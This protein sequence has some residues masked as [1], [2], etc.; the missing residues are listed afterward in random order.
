MNQWG[1]GANTQ[2]GLVFEREVDFHDLLRKTRG[3]EVKA[4]DRKAGKGVYFR[5]E[6]VA[7]CFRKHDFYKFLEE[8]KVDWRPKLSKKLLPDDALL[9]DARETLFVIEV[10]Y[11]QGVGSVDEKL[12][13]CDFKRKQYLKLLAGTGL[14]FEYVYVL[15]DWFKQDAYKDVLKY[16]L[17]V[18]CHFAFGSLPLSFLGLPE[19]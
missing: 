8:Q 1:G 17:S 7:R 9:V 19:P 10:K 2:T 15:S 12:Q 3:Y 18:N 14:K 11:Q 5:G 16:I 13:T 6:G 4:I